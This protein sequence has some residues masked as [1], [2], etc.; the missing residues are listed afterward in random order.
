MGIL[1]VSHVQGDQ[2]ELKRTSPLHFNGAGFNGMPVEPAAK[3]DFAS[4]MMDKIDDVNQLQGNVNQL[5]EL[6]LTDPDAVDVHELTIAM[7]KAEMAMGMTKA[8]VDKAVQAYKDIV[9]MR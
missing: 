4:L 5:N 1:D 3:G 6:M 7:A 9:N 8:V 2:F